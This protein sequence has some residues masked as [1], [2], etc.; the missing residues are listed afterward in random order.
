[1]KYAIVFKPRA[2]KDLRAINANNVKKIL[3]L[4]V[5]YRIK[6]RQEVYK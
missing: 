4:V 1:M 3:N 6:H 5:I 2:T